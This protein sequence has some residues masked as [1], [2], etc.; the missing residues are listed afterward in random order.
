MRSKYCLR[1]EAALSE[2]LKRSVLTSEVNRRLLN[3]REVN[4]QDGARK[5][6]ME[7]FCDKMSLSGYSRK[8]VKEI[9]RSGITGYERQLARS[10]KEGGGDLHR[11]SAKGIMKRR[12]KKVAEKRNWYKKRRSTELGNVGPKPDA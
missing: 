1:K 7:K 3:T 8:E 12:I 6:T 9:M 10:V 4:D 11:D 2:N 5:A